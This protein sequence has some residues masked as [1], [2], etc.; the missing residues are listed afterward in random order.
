MACDRIEEY[1]L[2]GDTHTA[3]LVGR[4]GS[5]DWLCLPRFDAA[6]CFAALL[7]THEHGYWKIAPCGEV[8][9]VERSYLGHSMVLSTVMT[10]ADGSVE[11]IDFMPKADDFDRAD[12]V[13]MVRGRKG[14]VAMRLELAFRLDYGHIVP[15]VRHDGCNVHAVAGPDH[16][17]LDAPMQLHG[18]N[19]LTCGDFEI[20]EGDSLAFTLTWFPSHQEPP[21]P[22]DA[23]HLLHVTRDWWHRWTERGTTCTR[24]HHAVQ[25]S[26][27]TLKALTYSPTG[28]IVAAP[29]ASLPEWIGG[30]R[31][32]DYRFCW[33]RDAGL[34]L[35]AL[36]RTGHSEEAV[37]WRQWLLRAVA[38]EPSQLQIMYGI[39]GERMLD[40]RELDWL[41]GYQGSRPVRVGNGAV[42]QLQLDVYGQVLGVFYLTYQQKVEPIA[43]SWDL[44]KCLLNDLEDRWHHPDAGIWEVRGNR[45]H[46]V[47]S[48]V[49]CWVAFDRA[50]KVA[51]EFG[52]DAPVERWTSARDT[53]HAEVCELGFN[54]DRNTF[55]Q[56]YGCD[57]VDASLLMIPLMGFLPPDDP[58]V[59]GTVEAIEKDLRIDGLVYRYRWHQTLDGIDHPEGAFLVCSFWLVEA[60]AMIGRE[61]D[62]EELFERLLGL[63]ND[64]G[65]YGEQYDPRNGRHLGNFPQAFS[66]VGLIS[67]ANRLDA[68]TKKGPTA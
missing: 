42:E 51:T 52:L 27:L 43:D 35:A 8:V 19:R 34:T 7:G 18:D 26:L 22:L 28:G 24:W 47:H 68:R 9:H 50:L 66:H 56:S 58:R 20:A 65:L 60:L 1:A 41:P 49:L 44:Q 59:I 2:I 32:W 14:R 54:A 62:A 67:A 45:R 3:A 30:E 33:L 21:E 6:A 61:K 57:A 10:T 40:E 53:I 46:F 36:L 16:L 39:G 55:V 5:I 11:I 23:E 31:N 12:V 38:G 64:V 63:A 15:W 17:H 37:A 48:K 29:T 25:R 4:D 13:R